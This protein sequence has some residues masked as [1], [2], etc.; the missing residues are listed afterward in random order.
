MSSWE[1]IFINRIQKLSLKDLIIPWILK[2]SNYDV[3]YVLSI[4]EIDLVILF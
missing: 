3:T 2:L 1:L 4:S